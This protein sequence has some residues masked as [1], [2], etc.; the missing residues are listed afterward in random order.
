MQNHLDQKMFLEAFNTIIDKG[1]KEQGYY[2][3]DDVKAWHDYDGYSC[4]ISYNKVEMTL[5]FHGKY[6]LDYKNEGLLESFI[7]KVLQINKGR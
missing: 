2:L 5:M 7:K 6:L 3:L 1:H 4:Y